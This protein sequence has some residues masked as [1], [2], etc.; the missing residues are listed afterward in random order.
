MKRRVAL[1]NLK[2]LDIRHSW[3]ISRYYYGIHME[4][5]RRWNETPIRISSIPAEIRI[6]YFSNKSALL[7]Q[8]AD[9]LIGSLSLYAS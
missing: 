3:H 4:E 7:Q 5:L 2:R 6:W 1:V 8:P 9:L